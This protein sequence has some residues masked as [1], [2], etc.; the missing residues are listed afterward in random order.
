MN[1]LNRESTAI[2]ILIGLSS[3]PMTTHA[4]A[5]AKDY[6]FRLVQT[7]QKSGDAVV[8]VRLIDKRSGKAVPDAIIIAKRIDMAPEA[9]AEMT[10]PL[11]QLP[12]PEP[13]IYAFKTKLTMEGRWRLSLGA[14]VQG[15]SGTVEGQLV[16]KATP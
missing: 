3:I 7:E 12:P 5:D 9:M 11:Q 6:E 10:S 4:R 1:I 16:L 2:A 8:A 13:G 14:K 15:E